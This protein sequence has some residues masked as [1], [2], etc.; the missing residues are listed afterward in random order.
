MNDTAAH[1]AAGASIASAG[2]AAW[3]ALAGQVAA[4]AASLVAIVAGIY[5][6]RYYRKHLRK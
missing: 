2:L 4:L 3:L 1:V 6:I 5:A